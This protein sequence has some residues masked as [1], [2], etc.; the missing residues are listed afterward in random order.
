MNDKIKEGKISYLII[1]AL[2]PTL[3]NF[4]LD[5]E[6]LSDYI[7][8]FDIWSSSILNIF[9]FLL[10]LFFFFFV[11]ILP[12]GCIALFVLCAYFLI[13]KRKIIY[14]IPMLILSLNLIPVNNLRHNVNFKENYDRRMEIVEAIK[15]GKLTYNEYG[16]VIDDQDIYNLE[17]VSL[18]GFVEVLYH[19]GNDYIISFWYKHLGEYPENDKYFIYSSGGI[20][21]FEN[22][23]DYTIIEILDDNWLYVNPQ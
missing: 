19:D 13:K 12:L 8:S 14:I 17:E 18:H 5:V 6:Y 10:A 9:M 2:L 15:T 20:E 11:S 4:F 22:E 21:L 16:R 23:T 1:L 7:E 3:I